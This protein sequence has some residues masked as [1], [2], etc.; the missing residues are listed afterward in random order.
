[1]HPG[2]PVSV[3]SLLDST[4]DIPAYETIMAGAG[5]V[6]K[7]MINPFLRDMNILLSTNILT[8]WQLSYKGKIIPREEYVTLTYAVFSD[9]YVVFVM[10]ENPQMK[11][12]RLAQIKE[13]PEKTMAG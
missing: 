9:C 13:I 3:Q 6:Y 11:K 7:R 12:M 8:D 1:M 2:R 10:P 4:Q 5:Q